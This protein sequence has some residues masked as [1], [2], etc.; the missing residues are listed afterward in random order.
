MA[1]FN[2]VDQADPP[3]V[4]P[5]VPAAKAKRGRTAKAPVKPAV[6]ALRSDSAAERIRRLP[7]RALGYLAAEIAYADLGKLRAELAAHAEAHP[8]IRDWREV[9]ESWKTPPKP[10]NVLP[11]TFAEERVFP[12]TV[13]APVLATY[14]PPTP[15]T[16][17]WRPRWR[18]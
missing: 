4:T 9:W 5:V 7:E 15:P 11:V 14:T 18:R 16:S 3:P 1:R 10:A 17:A 13:A 12:L 6:K 2:P 8:E